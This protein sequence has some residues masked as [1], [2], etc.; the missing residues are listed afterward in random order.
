MSKIY[1]GHLG[2]AQWSLENEGPEKK[3]SLE[4]NL[5]KCLFSLKRSILLRFANLKNWHLQNYQIKL[6][7]CLKLTWDL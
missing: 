3:E 2:T 6:T 5:S 7:I 1:V 4:Q